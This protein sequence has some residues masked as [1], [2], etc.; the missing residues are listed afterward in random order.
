[1]GGFF[2]GMM[3]GRMASRPV[4]VNNAP[5]GPSS[6]GP[7]QGGPGNGGGGTA[8]FGC[9]SVVAILV[10][11]ALIVAMV[12]SLG[13]CS[14]SDVAAST[15]Q[16]EKLPASAVAETAYYTDEDGGWIRS[17]SELESG[18]RAFYD[19]TGVQPYVYILPNGT[20]TSAS[21]LSERA[22]QLYDQLFSDEGHFLLVFCDDG[23]GSFT[24]GY[25]V[26]SQAKTVMDDEAVG[27][28]ADYLDRYYNDLSLSEE[29]IFSR[30][31]ADTGQRIMSVTVSP[32][33]PVAACVAVV[34]V[35]G[36]SYLVFRKV[37]A[38]RRAERERRERIL[39]TPLEAFGDADVED[40]AKKYEKGA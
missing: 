16:R 34:G 6:G 39:N 40:R 38:D 20:S 23:N 12:S 36:I 25:A 4:I 31:F 33:V 22:A 17:P 19:D 29:E 9:A 32:V 3:L 11:V 10:A 30:A 26:G 8:F 15:V 5:S 27:I 7:G 37:R 14:G 1:M 35:A 21:E 24:C 18:L 2:T 28:L 13:S